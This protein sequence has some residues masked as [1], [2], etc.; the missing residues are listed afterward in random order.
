MKTQALNVADVIENH[1]TFDT[2]ALACTREPIFNH[3]LLLHVL[4]PSEARPLAGL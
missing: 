4:P 3:S 1:G 2:C